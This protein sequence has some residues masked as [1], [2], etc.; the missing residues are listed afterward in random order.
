[1]HQNAPATAHAPATKLT[2]RGVLTGMSSVGVTSLVLPANAMVAAAPATRVP[3]HVDPACPIQ[4][5]KRLA[6]LVCP[7]YRDHS[8]SDE[9]REGWVRGKVD[10]I[11][12]LAPGSQSTGSVITNIRI[13]PALVDGCYEAAFDNCWGWFHQAFE[14][15]WQSGWTPSPA[16]R[17]VGAMF[18]LIRHAMAVH[19]AYQRRG[20]LLLDGSQAHLRDPMLTHVS[21]R[22]QPHGYFEDWKLPFSSLETVFHHALPTDRRTREGR[23][24]LSTWIAPDRKELDR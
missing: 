2:R 14:E 4:V 23:A 8:S 6:E 16:H 7:G 9:T 22:V 19:D 20:S 18:A 12:S 11:A 10:H 13:D 17:S 15:D 5:M 3:D 21:Q 24:G 1:M